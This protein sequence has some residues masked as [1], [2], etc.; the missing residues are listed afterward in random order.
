MANPRA[1]F[2]EKLAENGVT[3]VPCAFNSPRSPVE[4]VA[5]N[6][7]TEDELP[8]MY[9]KELLTLFY[10]GD[11]DAVKE[12]VASSG[13][14]RRV[15]NA[16]NANGET[17][18]MK[19]CRRALTSKPP[20]CNR[21]LAVVALLFEFG[22][23]PAVCCDSGKNVLHD[24]FWTAKP[25]PPEALRVMEALVDMVMLATT[26]RSGILDLMLSQ[27]KHGY[28]PLDY[29][30]PASQPN[31][32]R[33]FDKIINWATNLEET[34][35]ADDQQKKLLL[36]DSD[37]ESTVDAPGEPTGSP[38]L[39]YDEVGAAVAVA[40]NSPEEEE[41]PEV[42]ID[43][44]VPSS[45]SSAEEEED[46]LEEEPP[47]VEPPTPPTQHRVRLLELETSNRGLVQT[48]IGDAYPDDQRLLAQL[49]SS[50]ASFL[51]SD[52][53]D[54][55][56]T[57]VAVSPNFVAATGYSPAEVLGRN[58]RFLQGPGT[59]TRQVDLIRR[60]LTTNATVRV[61][62][63]NYR[64]S[65]DAFPNNFL[66]TPLRLRS[67]GQVAFFL[68]IQN[69]PEHLAHDRRKRLEAAGFEWISDDD[70]GVFQGD[71]H[72]VSPGTGDIILIGGENRR[73]LPRLRF[74]DDDEDPQ[75]KFRNSMQSLPSTETITDVYTPPKRKASRAEPNLTSPTS[76]PQGKKSRR[77]A[78][79]PPA[80]P[81]TDSDPNFVNRVADACV[82]S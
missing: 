2:L 39:R 77:G 57:I 1:Y 44:I 28:T 3:T 76:L 14:P 67:T 74:D 33:L 13:D 8:Q 60:A 31:W 38:V 75:R 58:C 72:S 32:R 80:I 73:G 70:D 10:Q 17:V 64:K 15:V 68:G 25:P 50:E 52:C 55:D 12:R 22:A 61:S 37:E 9:D 51:M 19:V 65:G 27:D 26:G 62:L 66:L 71:H 82:I 45:S 41:E 56:A 59:E 42:V 46:E 69:C 53:S 16:Q 43:V 35:P 79:F 34:L 18:L 36:L 5:L 20:E 47:A 49:C 29:V 54:P 7:R 48:V 81:R 30:I 63:V 4:C 6:Y 40:G 78:G 11:L 23:N 21:G 24:V